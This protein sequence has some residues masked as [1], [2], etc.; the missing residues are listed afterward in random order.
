MSQS[1]EVIERVIAMRDNGESYGAIAKYL[2]SKGFE[3]ATRHGRWHASTVRSILRS[4]RLDMEASRAADARRRAIEKRIG[5]VEYGNAFKRAGEAEQ[6]ARRSL[7]QL[8]AAAS[9][10]GE[11]I[12]HGHRAAKKAH[13]AFTLSEEHVGSFETV[14]DWLEKLASTAEAEA[15]KSEKTA[16]EA[17]KE[18]RR[19]DGEATVAS[20]RLSAAVAKAG[21][22]GWTE[23]SWSAIAKATSGSDM[24]NRRAASAHAEVEY[25]WRRAS[26]DASA[27]KRL[28]DVVIAIEPLLGKSRAVRT[29]VSEAQTSTAS[30]LE[31]VFH[32]RDAVTGAVTST[33]RS[34]DAHDAVR[35]PV[36]D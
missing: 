18:A 8:Q 20:R 6:F 30:T 17:V 16:E 3:T 14:F 12:E 36:T 27:A 31:R 7:G 10:I 25:A 34:I 32:A 19:L 4:H 35:R 1:D 22:D 21:E 15:R 11:A 13:S 23:R 2:N 26:A 29:A 24:A 9:S 5:A 28:H 33:Q